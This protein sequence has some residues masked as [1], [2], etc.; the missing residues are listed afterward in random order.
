M[1]MSTTSP[2]MQET[3][4]SLSRVAQRI[5][6]PWGL[7]LGGIGF[8]YAGIKAN[9]YLYNGGSLLIDELNLGFYW[10]ANRLYDPVIGRFQGM[11][12]LSEMFT[13]VSP[14]VYGFNNPLKFN[15]P[16]GLSGGCEECVDLNEVVVYATRLPRV[17]PD[18]G[19]LMRDLGRSSSPIYRNISFTAQNEGLSQAH[20]LFK[21]G[22]TLHFSSGEVIKYRDSEFMR[23]IRAMVAYGVTGSMVAAAASPILIESLGQAM[24]A[25]ALGNVSVEAGLQV[26]TSLMFN[27][28]LSGVDMADIALSGVFGKFGFVSQAFV[29]F[30]YQDGFSTTFGFGDYNKSFLS[31]GLDLGV[32]SFNLGH[33][34]VLKISGINSNVINIY[35]NSFS[36]GRKTLGDY[37]KSKGK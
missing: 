27:R 37:S 17:A 12:K 20:Q 21:R 8:Q 15:D 5:G 26:S 11:D 7:E 35:N 22:S 16:T 29:D 32:G 34:E 4:Y 25:R 23:G 28:N 24:G 9:K 18:Y 6:N 2:I 33:S 36:F 14:M 30:N 1:L 13:S 31:T 10:T 3:H 19:S